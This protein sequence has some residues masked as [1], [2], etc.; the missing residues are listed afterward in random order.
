MKL[1]NSS[2]HFV[3][4]DTFLQ[5]GFAPKLDEL[6]ERFDVDSQRM[7]EALR[8]L[9]DYHG[10]VLHPHNDEI[11][12]AHPFSTVPTGFLVS[13]G[14]R[15]WWGNCAWCSLGLA[16]LA[17][18]PV[19]IR[20]APGF[21]RRTIELTIE[22]GELDRHDFV[23]HFPTPMA[24]AWDNVIATCTTMLVFDDEAHVEEWC[25]KHGK[26]KGDVQPIQKVWEFARE[27]YG[28]HAD[29]DWKKPSAREAA[30]IFARH[31]LSGPIW[32]LPEQDGHF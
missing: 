12:V 28:K 16:A 2:L 22:D 6:S 4:I 15:E 32:S 17:D 19:T 11:W 30:E 24:R 9:Q 1:T 26:D 13:S 8:E 5:K 31:G 10:V 14:E 20:T 27:W 25:E 18:S 3:I 7:R 23:V 29:P 21:D